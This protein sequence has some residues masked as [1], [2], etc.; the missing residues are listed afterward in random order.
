MNSQ[1]CE[2]F[3]RHR[4]HELF[5]SQHQTNDA[6]IKYSSQKV[7]RHAYEK[8]MTMLQKHGEHKR[9]VNF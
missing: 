9:S 2:I 4:N 7:H 5:C 3:L 8:E 1:D 6:I